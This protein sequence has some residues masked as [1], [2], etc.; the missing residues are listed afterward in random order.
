MIVC[1]IVVTT[2]VADLQLNDYPPLG[3][4]AIA[5]PA[6][7]NVHEQK[8]ADAVAYAIASENPASKDQAI[9]QA[10]TFGAREPMIRSLARWACARQLTA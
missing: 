1:C 9:V 3:Q 10:T 6:S 7:L 8:L 5:S 4:W 2:G